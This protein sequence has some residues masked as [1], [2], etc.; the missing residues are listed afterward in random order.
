MGRVVRAH[1]PQLQREVALKLLRTQST[2]M[3]TRLIREAQAMARLSDP[4]V[5]PVYDVGE[6]EGMVFIAMEFV[7]GR[8]L[9][10]WLRERKRGLDEIL[11]V[12]AAAGRG[13]AAAHAAGIVHRDFKPGNVLVGF[14]GEQDGRTGRVRVMDFGLARAADDPEGTRH[15][16]EFVVASG[17]TSGEMLAEPLTEA[18]TVMGTPAYMA[19]E[20][21]RGSTTDA[22]SDQYSFCV[23]LWEAVYGMRPF[24]ADS[25]SE[26]YRLKDRGQPVAPASGT[27]PRR[28]RA[29]LL[30]GLDPD[31]A[32]RFVGMRELLAELAP[33]R[34]TTRWRVVGA[35]GAIATIAA[36]GVAA[37]A[38]H[39]SELCRGADAAL[40]GIW[41]DGRAEAID[42][43][44]ASTEVP[45]AR[46]TAMRVRGGLDRWATDW[47]SAYTDACEA[48]QIRGEQSVDV[49]DARMRCLDGG[50]RQLRALV[51]VLARADA[52]TL[53]RATQ[54]VAALPRIERCAD[55]EI[56]AAQVP[57]PEPE[58]APE[59]DT[60]RERLADARA[61]DLAGRYDEGRTMY[62]ELLA[63]AYALGYGPLL[64]EVAFRRGW[65]EERSGSFAAAE[66]SLQSAFFAA[67]EAG[68]D[69][70]AAEAA[71]AL[72]LVVGVDRARHAEALAWAERARSGSADGVDDITEAAICSNLGNFAFA[73]GA[74]D[75]S[76]EL[77][78]CA[79]AAK[80]KVLG[81]ESSDVAMT[82]HNLGN[83]HA[84]RGETD[85]ALAHE[86]QALAIVRRTLG[87][88]HPSVAEAENS[89]GAIH[90]GRGAHDEAVIHFERALAIW[91]PALGPDHPDVASVL[92]NLGAAENERGDFARSIAYQERAL[93]LR[94]RTLGRDHPDVGT[95]LNNLG[96][97]LRAQ[98]SYDE[99]LA[100]LER[101]RE[102]W[103]TALGPE[104]PDVAITVGNI[105]KVHLLRG[106]PEP[107]LEHARRALVIAEASLG[108]DHEGLGYSLTT[109]GEA[110]LVLDRAAEAIAPL[111]RALEVRRRGSVDPVRTAETQFALAKALRATRRDRTR[112]RELAETALASWRAAGEHTADRAREAETWLR[113][114]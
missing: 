76:L 95:S 81:R 20:Q 69:A 77:H 88:E 14:A 108:P 18:G 44:F 22:R 74:Y 92:G 73:R 32:R 59:I 29:L 28:L 23:A 35:T 56:L 85:E 39:R 111:E 48:T 96:A 58:L 99:A 75:E 100:R 79:L 10:R 103:E 46:D 36:V 45:Y 19:P 93:A 97:V 105:A 26:L 113:R 1:D 40:E 9:G 71:S 107:A 112:A 24:T 15:S 37:A 16:D 72:A 61:L 43:A 8:T 6:H 68:M 17:A 104:H 62:D 42:V 50:R 82:L 109:I 30:R 7:D 21:H 47:A 89:L 90:F 83:V 101:A 5:L 54:A 52:A 98:G 51:D 4:N 53:P 38:S 78:R 63:R 25:T 41:N 110:L 84:A 80:E 65:L 67:R 91:E 94:E 60:I 12:F 33:P 34:A 49:M 13:L 102:I 70:L 64:A 2:A 87:D 31:P 106:A 11:A 57:P 3:R 66:D 114:R 86:Q 27:V 55:P